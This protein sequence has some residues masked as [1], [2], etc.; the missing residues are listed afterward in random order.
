MNV[1]E[2]KI[3]PLQ[4]TTADREVAA[5][6][7]AR[8]RALAPMLRARAVETERNRQVP[9]EAVEA[10]KAAGLVRTLTPKRWGG[11]EL[12]FEDAFDIGLEIGKSTCGSS[13]WCLSYMTDHAF[14]LADFPDEAQ[15]DVWSRDPDAC[16]ATSF[17]PNGKVTPVDGGFRLDGEWPFASNVGHCGWIMMGGMYFGGKEPDLLLFLVPKTDVGIRDVWQNAGL[18]GSGSNTVVAEDIFVPAHRA[19]SF[20]GIREGRTPGGE[21]NPGWIYHVPIVAAGVQALLSPAIGIARGAYDDF[22]AWNRGRVAKYTMAQVAEQAP[23][24]IRIAEAE[25]HL[26]V[27]EMLVRNC[28]KVVRENHPISFEQRIHNLRDFTFAIRNVVQAT[29]SLIQVGGATAMFDDNSLQ[30]AWRD[31]Q[32]IACHVYLNFEAAAE[33]FGRLQLGVDRNAHNPMF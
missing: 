30:R 11:F 22:I 4:G 18:R 25:A 7:V 33:N 13:A 31:V 15:H 14:L 5:T 8:A 28:L 19:C 12:D 16:I 10:Y 3:R 26:Q 24:Q 6:L 32:T 20:A 2:T 9:V 23:F 17:V 27:A 29:N 1:V 21:V